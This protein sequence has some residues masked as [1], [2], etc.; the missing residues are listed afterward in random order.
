MSAGQTSFQ[1]AHLAAAQ[2][3]TAR[4]PEFRVGATPEL[5][6]GL[7]AALKAPDSVMSRESRLELECVLLQARIVMARRSMS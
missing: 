5:I 4:C 3:L 2:P 7:E 1:R 6:A